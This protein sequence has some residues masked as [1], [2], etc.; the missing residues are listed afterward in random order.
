MFYSLLKA[1]TGN[2]LHVVGFLKVNNM[3]LSLSWSSQAG[4]TVW[5]HTTRLS[6][7][8]KRCRSEYDSH[9]Q[10]GEGGR[11]SPGT[12]PHIL[13]TTPSSCSHRAWFCIPIVT[14]RKASADL[15]VQKLGLLESSVPL[16]KTVPWNL[17]YTSASWELGLLN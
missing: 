13:P 15:I 4:R 8:N 17:C 2:T 3:W 12:L 1:T 7:N 6:F 9:P 11:F 5:A 16:G 14:S 10:P